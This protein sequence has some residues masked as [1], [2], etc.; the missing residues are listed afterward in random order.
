MGKGRTLI[1]ESDDKIKRNRGETGTGRKKKESGERREGSIERG[2]E[3]VGEG[4]GRGRIDGR[5]RGRRKIY[6]SER[7]KHQRMQ[8]GMRRKRRM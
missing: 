5:K 4:R 3:D 2:R 1:G 6:T 7:K 8:R